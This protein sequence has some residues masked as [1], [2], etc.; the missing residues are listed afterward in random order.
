MRKVIAKISLTNI[1]RNAE[2]FAAY[3]GKKLCAVVKA[4]GYGHGAEEV[5]NALTGVADF[6]A[7]SLLEEAIAIRTAACGKDILI[8]TPP[9]CEEDVT[10]AAENGFVI[11]VPDL[12]TAKLVARV[13][14]KRKL[15]A[16]V[17]L[18]VNTGMNRYGMNGSMLGKTCTFLKK[19]RRVFVEGLYSHLY[20]YSLTSAIKQK[21]LFVRFREIF[22]RYHPNGI[23]HLSATYG[24]LLGKEFSF[25]MTRVGIGLYGYFPDGAKDVPDGAL[26]ALPLQKAMRVETLVS[27][28]RTYSFGG[29]GYGKA[30]RVEK[31]AKLC[32]CRF[33]YA[34]GF[35]RKRENGVDGAFKS[36]NNLC[37]DAS[38]RISSL[39]RGKKV[40][41]LTDAA[42]TA[43]ETNTISYEVLCAAT[44]RA[45][46]IYE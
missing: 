25:D 42:K 3:T 12:W 15:T 19:N 31:G 9:L 46:R 11:T 8:F 23:C 28:N 10:Q 38:I 45:E 30:K 20:E 29:A 35:L 34:D 5:V 13:C 44:R 27:A 17:H 37:M 24:S 41:I 39:R 14:E 18:K 1:K 16:R 33:G 36:A 32:V 22:K 2:A 7:V 21:D 26:R 40:D 6:F 4:D 43:K